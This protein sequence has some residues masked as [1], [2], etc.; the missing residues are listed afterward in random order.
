M[1]YQEYPAPAL[2]SATSFQRPGP[3]RNSGR[4]S[5]EDIWSQEVRSPLGL[6][7]EEPH[8]PP[9]IPIALSPTTTELINS[10]YAITAAASKHP[11]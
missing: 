9:P 1:E 7:H 6:D 2:W 8:C 10:I 11:S 3:I 5:S 4:V